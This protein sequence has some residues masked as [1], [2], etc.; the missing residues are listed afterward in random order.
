MSGGQGGSA[1]DLRPTSW[2]R[3]LVSQRVRKRADEIFA[4]SRRSATSAAP[5][6]GAWSWPASPPP[7]SA[8]PAIWW[9]LRGSVPAAES[10]RQKHRHFSHAACKHQTSNLNTQPC[11]WQHRDKWR[12]GPF[13]NT[14]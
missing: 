12:Y 13:L 1:L 10:S 5:A 4:G 3:Y 6:I 14:L 11:P 7:W 9:G 8:R 2:P